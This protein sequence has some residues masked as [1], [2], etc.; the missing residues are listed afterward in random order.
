MIQSINP[1]TKQLLKEYNEISDQEVHV[2]IR[3]SAEAFELWKSI[4][5]EERTKPITQLATYLEEHK[6]VLAQTISLEMGKPISEAIAEIEKCALSTHY[7]AKHGKA[8]L[9][10]VQIAQ[11]DTGFEKGNLESYVQFDPLGVILAIMP[12]NY[13]FWQIIRAAVPAIL[14]GNTVIL[15][16]ASNVP[17]CAL[18]LEELFNKSGFPEGVFQT[19][20]VSSSRV[21]QMIENPHIAAITLTGS[22]EAGAV[23]ASQAGRAIKK[24]VLELGG[25]DPFI[26]MS[27]ADLDLTVLGAVQSRTLNCGQSCISAKRFIVH[28]SL[29]ESFIQKM[30]EQLESLQV[31]NPLRPDTQLGPLANEQILE[32]ISNQVKSSIKSGAKLITGGMELNLGGYF[33]APTLLSEITPEMSLFREESFGP[34]AAVIR[35]ETEEEAIKLANS[36]DYGLG[37]SIWS[38]DIK[39]CKKIAN[40]LEVGNVFVNKIVRSDPKMPFGG[41][42]N[43]GYGREL[44]EFGIREFTNIKSVVVS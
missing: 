10:A 40:Q 34:V 8:M 19:V 15:K 2:I 37:A 23:V 5:I 17:Q 7:F 31:G 11:E 39:N 32:Q 43:S 9:N 44:G 30:K 20:L 42:K 14:A 25:S 18:T 6:E 13:P 22:K 1:A 41:V 4:S 27:D 3:N 12:W 21:E 16:H 28:S 24:A 38:S 35:F 33:Y 26:V 36:S 29:Y